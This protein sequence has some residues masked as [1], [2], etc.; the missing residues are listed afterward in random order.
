MYFGEYFN[1]KEVL[2]IEKQLTKE[3][4]LE[5]SVD[6]YRIVFDEEPHPA[7]FSGWKFF[8]T[9]RDIAENRFGRFDVYPFDNKVLFER[10]LHV[11]RM[12]FARHA[13]NLRSGGLDEFENGTGIVKVENY[14]DEENL[15]GIKSEIEKYPLAEVKSNHN[16]LNTTAHNFPYILSFV[17]NTDVFPRMCE[18]VR[19]RTDDEEVQKFFLSTSYVQ[20]LDSVPNNGDVQKN[21]HSDIFFPNV[22]YWYFPWDVEA[23]NG[24]FMFAEHSQVLTKELLDFYYE[25]SIKVVND[26]WD[27]FRGRSHAEGSFRVKSEELERM[28]LQLS[29]QSVKA[30]TLIYANVSGFHCRG[31]VTSRSVRNSIHGA[32]RMEDCFNVE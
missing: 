7:I 26:T 28:N 18:A 1:N 4:F 31:E 16:L 22:K 9:K 27:K 14:L 6:A 3:N 23:E 11:F 10:G 15:E 20:R 13:H 17:Q 32:I 2:E 5:K 12:I 24:P 29:P 21:C 8:A 19:R 25:E 30:N